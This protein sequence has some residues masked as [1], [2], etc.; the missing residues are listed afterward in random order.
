MRTVKLQ[1]KTYIYTFVGT[2]KLQLKTYI[3]IHL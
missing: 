3:Y 2:I 1:L